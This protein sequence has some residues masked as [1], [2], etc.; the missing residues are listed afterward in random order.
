MWGAEMTKYG[1]CIASSLEERVRGERM[2]KVPDTV[3]STHNHDGGIV[4]DIDRGQIFN[5][6]N[7]GSRIFE[8]LKS[9][10][11]EAQIVKNV[12]QEFE[13]SAD[14]AEADLQEFLE[15]LRGHRLVEPYE[16]L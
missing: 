9:G 2:Y 3:R 10:L 14:V 6:N 5:F 7:V 15:A 8:L 16:S 13:V 4:L 1:L 11:S 12:S